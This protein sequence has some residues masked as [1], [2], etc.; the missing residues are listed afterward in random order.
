MT[1]YEYDR[2]QNG[3]TVLHDRSRNSKYKDGVL[4]AK[5]LL[6]NFYQQQERERNRGEKMPE[7]KPCPWCGKLPT[8]ETEIG[9]MSR[10]EYYRLRCLTVHCPVKPATWWTELIGMAVFD[11]NRRANNETD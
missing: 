4:S 3:L 11:W 8:V 5:S 1:R 9:E 6:H 2:L 7:L 10:R